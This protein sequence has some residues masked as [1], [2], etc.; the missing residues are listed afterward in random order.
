MGAGEVARDWSRRLLARA[1][2]RLVPALTPRRSSAGPAGIRAQAL[3]PDGALVDD[4]RLRRRRSD[5][6]RPQRA[7]ARRHIVARDRRR[8]RR[9]LPARLG[10]TRSAAGLA[11]PRPS[12]TLSASEGWLSSSEVHAGAAGPDR[13]ARCGR[14]RGTRRA[15]PRGRAS[16]R[17]AFQSASASMRRVIQLVTGSASELEDDE[18]EERERHRLGWRIPPRR[19]VSR[20]IRYAPGTANSA[21]HAIPFGMWLLEWWPISCASTTSTWRGGKPSTSVSQS[22]MRAR[23][24][25]PRRIGVHERGV[26]RDL[27]HLHRDALDALLALEALRRGDQAR[28]AQRLGVARRQPREDEREGRPERDEDRRAGNPPAV[29]EAARRDPSR[30]GARGRRRGTRRR[31]RPSS[32]RPTRGSRLG[33]VVA[34]LPP[35]LGEPESELAQPDEAEAEHAE[36]H[37]GADPAGGRLPREARAVAGVEPERGEQHHLGEEEPGRRGS[38]RSPRPARRTA[39][40]RRRRRRSAAARARRERRSGAAARRTPPRANAS[41]ARMTTVRV[42]LP[43]ARGPT[44]LRRKLRS[45]P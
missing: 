12:P 29:A 7:V 24:P 19:R 43:G 38:A 44:G 15:P 6:P 9:A 35:K 34:P 27:L 31:A 22:T 40:R 8:D 36:Q 33:Q 16:T 13:R 20:A 14:G 10:L 42:R 3:A 2:R 21:Y 26:V 45:E 28:V 39:G 41:T 4:F 5:R 37:P 18:H 25:E 11:T 17:S 30:S 32:T 1:A 23:R